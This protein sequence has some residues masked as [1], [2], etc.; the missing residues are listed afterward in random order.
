MKFFAERD[1]MS[2]EMKVSSFLSMMIGE[3]QV[4]K[5]SHDQ[6]GQRYIE[7]TRAGQ[8][9]LQLMESLLSERSKFSGSGAEALLG[10]LNDILVSRREMSESEAID[11]HQA[12]S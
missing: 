5:D 8:R 6:F 12:K 2:T 4:F 3:L 10:A 7:A 1:L 9:L 11:H